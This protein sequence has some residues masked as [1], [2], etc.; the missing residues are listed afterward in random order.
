MVQQITSLLESIPGLSDP[1]IDNSIQL[2]IDFIYNSLREQIG[3]ESGKTP[4]IIDYAAHSDYYRKVRFSDIA[5][6]TSSIKYLLTQLHLKRDIPLLVDSIEWLIKQQHPVTGSWP[7]VSTETLYSYPSV[8]IDRDGS[9]FDMSKNE[10]WFN[11]I[12]TI[13]TL[14]DWVYFLEKEK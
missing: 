10:S 7:V 13:E 1:K 6:T 9:K 11:T 2:S 4:F 3:S 14:L 5:A 8:S 12:S